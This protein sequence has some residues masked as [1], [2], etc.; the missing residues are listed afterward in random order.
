MPEE[1]PKKNFKIPKLTT[2]ELEEFWEGFQK[3]IREDF[4]EYSPKTREYFLKKDFTKEYFR[5]FLRKQ[6]G[7]VFL[8]KWKASVIGFLI[9]FNSYGGVS[10][11][12][13]IGV[14]K[15]FRRQGAGKAL[16]GEW[17]KWA[18]ENGAH[19]LYL[20]ASEWNREFY[21][22]CGFKE[23]GFMEKGHFGADDYWFGKIIAKPD[24]KRFLK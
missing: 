24:E 18:K 1:K 21:E 7:V 14:K 3:I 13:W 8:V 6:K 2:K 22:G 17:E 19:R 16:L 20:M 9:A 12:P 15:E 4:P 11:C 10:F 23:E 5:E